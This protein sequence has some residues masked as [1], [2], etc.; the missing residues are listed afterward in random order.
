MSKARIRRIV[1]KP[2][3][4]VRFPIKSGYLY[5][6]ST[7]PLLRTHFPGAIG[8]KTGSTIKAG[9]CFVGVVRRGRR[10]IGVVLLHSPNSLLQA[11]K[12]V[13]AAFKLRL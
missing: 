9:H 10:T 4:K 5:V 2:Q 8:L 7:N 6:N 3:A 11:Q 12:L 13:T 1:R